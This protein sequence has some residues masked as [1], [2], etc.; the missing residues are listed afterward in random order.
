MA[1]A[2]NERA[3]LGGVVAD[4]LAEE[5][6][7]LDV[8]CG[9]A[10]PSV[11]L[12]YDVE[13][14]AD[15]GDVL[16]DDYVLIDTCNPTHDTGRLHA[17]ELDG[18]DVDAVNSMV[19]D[20][21]LDTPAYTVVD[22]VTQMLTYHTGHHIDRERYDREQWDR[23]AAAVWASNLSAMDVD[24]VGMT[25]RVIRPGSKGESVFG[26]DA[27]ADMTTCSGEISQALFDHLADELDGR[28]WDVDT[29]YDDGYG[30]LL[31]DR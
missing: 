11:A 31:A 17:R 2:P 8:G 18:L 5:G 21:G 1:E 3:A 4:Y 22:G 27:A 16:P 24:A 25:E 26:I 14:A 30:L 29:G 19:A 12:P 6:A 28:G 13:A 10:H 23:R 15:Y 20:L 7:V 9:P